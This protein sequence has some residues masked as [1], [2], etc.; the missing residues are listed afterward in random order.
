MLV[1][2][3]SVSG[4]LVEKVSM[5]AKCLES[6][7][8]GWILV[9]ASMVVSA[10]LAAEVQLAVMVVMPVD[11]KCVVLWVVVPGAIQGKCDELA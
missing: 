10:E 5:V 9:A 6:D 3:A 2:E 4:Q 7:P 1:D 8:N 11:E